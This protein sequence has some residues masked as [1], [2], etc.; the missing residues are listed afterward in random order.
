MTDPRPQ[1]GTPVAGLDHIDRPA[2]FGLLL[3]EGRLATV[4][5]QRAGEAAYHDLPGGAVEAGESEAEAVAREFAEETGLIVRAL[6]C[7]GQARQ[8][9]SKSDGTPV[10]NIGGFWTLELVAEDAAAKVEDDHELAWLE[11]LDA[12]T[13]L[14][15]DAH[16]WA[17]TAWLRR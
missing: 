17:V 6:E 15:H 1:F 11:P 13:S 7:I 4:R 16:A 10:N 8:Y 5:I 3:R 14:R 9:F 12:L 2:A